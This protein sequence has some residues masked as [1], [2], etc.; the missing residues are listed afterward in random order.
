MVGSQPCR[1]LGKSCKKGVENCKNSRQSK[2]EFPITL[3]A[4]AK[5]LHLEHYRYLTCPNLFLE[6]IP[7]INLTKFD[8]LESQYP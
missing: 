8:H 2:I 5:M 3:I 4:G 7:S 1:E 6:Y